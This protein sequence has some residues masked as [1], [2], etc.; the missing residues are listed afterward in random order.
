MST[1][2]TDYF[3]TVWRSQLLGDCKERDSASGTGRS[4][5]IP[6]RIVEKLG[7]FWMKGE[8]VVVDALGCG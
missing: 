7:G 2:A 5:L 4:L 3:R 1:H 8:A 6:E